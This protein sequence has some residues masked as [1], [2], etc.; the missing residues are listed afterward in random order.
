[1]TSQQIEPHARW[2]LRKSLDE[3]ADSYDAA[4]AAIDAFTRA[5]HGYDPAMPRPGAIARL[6]AAMHH[7][8]ARRG[9]ARTLWF[10]ATFLLA[11]SF[12]G[13]ISQ[14]IMRQ[15]I[16]G[17]I[18]A[19][20]ALAPGVLL[21]LALGGT[22]RLLADGRYSARGR[23]LRQAS[24]P[25]PPAG[26]PV[27]AAGRPW[28]FAVVLSGCAAW[29]ATWL[30]GVA[31]IPVGPAVACAALSAAVGAAAFVAAGLP[32]PTEAAGPP[33]RDP[34]PGAPPRRLLAR[35]QAAQQGLRE[36]ARQWS[37]VARACGLAL[38]G[39]MEAEAALN[40]LLSTGELGD[41]PAE[42]L[43]TFHT[44]MLVTLLRYAPDTLRTPLRAASQRLLPN[45]KQ[46][47]PA[48]DGMIR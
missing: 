20:L 9:W 31:D 43:D 42:G 13:W 48:A 29:I 41:M 25:R 4:A 39:S 30:I 45:G 6:R 2:K 1:M 14:Q 34:R 18:P 7:G 12:L 24:P 44:Q 5:A 33:V 32:A 3:L 16:P 37:T 28:L 36:H 46:P 38:E 26:S 27:S 15:F 35:E 22:A 11:A 47:L 10:A 21:A 23:F 19:A 8:V 17:P 40:R